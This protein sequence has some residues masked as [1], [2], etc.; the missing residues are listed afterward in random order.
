MLPQYEDHEALISL[1]M[2]DKSFR[3]SLHRYHHESLPSLSHRV[4][5]LPICL[6]LS[7]LFIVVCVNVQ[8]ATVHLLR[9]KTMPILSKQTRGELKQMDQT[10][11]ELLRENVLSID[12]W[13]RFFQLQTYISQFGAF[14]DVDRQVKRRA[15]RELCQE[16]PDDLR[17]CRRETC[18][19]RILS[20]QWV[21]I[22]IRT[23]RSRTSRCPNWKVILLTS[24]QEVNGLLRIV[25]LGI[26]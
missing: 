16:I 15:T 7:I 19:G 9:P 17:E 18:R 26:A 1:C 24:D 4:N 13:H 23:R 3:S 20:F 2:R 5:C 14:F 12:R 11:N 25:S 10:M 6:V 21:N 8:I 22:S